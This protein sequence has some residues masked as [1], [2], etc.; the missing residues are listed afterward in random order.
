MLEKFNRKRGKKKVEFTLEKQKKKKK[1]SISLSKNG[2]IL[3]AKKLLLKGRGK[4]IMWGYGTIPIFL[5]G[6]R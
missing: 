4:H 3:P 1:F 2:K 6:K 5:W